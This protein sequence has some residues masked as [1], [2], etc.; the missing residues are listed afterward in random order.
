MRSATVLLGIGVLSIASV[1]ASAS[2]LGRVDRG[3]HVPR[4]TG[5][6][7]AIARQR[8]AHANCSLRVQGAKLVQAEIQTVMRQSPGAGG[9]SSRV[10][11]WLNPVCRGEAAYGP[12]IREP[13][14]TAGPTRLVSGFY[15]VGGPLATFSDAGCKRPT[16]PAGA[17]TVEVT[18]ASGA[19]VATQS[20]ADGHFVEIPLPAGSYTITGTFLGAIINGVHPKRSE[21][22]VIPPHHMVRQ[23]FFLDIP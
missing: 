21:S 19:V 22:V 18:D 14:V 10:A 13:V 15:L 23:D 8:A 6:T 9:H 12:E 16:P 1:S 4:L 3:C 11:V 5:L 17:G 20:S 7:L 2:P